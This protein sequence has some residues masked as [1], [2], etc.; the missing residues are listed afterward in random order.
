MQIKVSA[1][2]KNKGGTIV[3]VAPL[4]SIASV[5][6]LLNAH[7]IGAAPVVDTLGALVGMISERD[8]IRGIAQLGDA[9]LAQPAESLMT[10]AVRTCVPNDTIVDIMQLMTDQR[11]R[12]VPVLVDGKLSGLVSIGDVV[13]QRL[14]EAQAE[15]ESLRNY[16]AGAPA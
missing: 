14:D 9:V 6:S 16:I 10:R 2:L 11:I 1:L 7:R 13:K 12:H 3:T 15:L 5:A 4:Q 8:I